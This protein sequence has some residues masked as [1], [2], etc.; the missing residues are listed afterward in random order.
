MGQ[1]EGVCKGYEEGRSGVTGG[2]VHVSDTIILFIGL[3]H[4]C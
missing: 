1:E 3:R 4:G 2:E